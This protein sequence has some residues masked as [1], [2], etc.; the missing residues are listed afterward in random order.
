MWN[1]FDSLGA[2]CSAKLKVCLRASKMTLRR[3]FRFILLR[4]KSKDEPNFR[5]RFQYYMHSPFTDDSRSFAVS[6]HTSVSLVNTS[7]FSHRRILYALSTLH[8]LCEQKLFGWDKRDLN[9]SSS[10]NI[11][12]SIRQPFAPCLSARPTLV[13][14][15][16]VVHFHFWCNH[17]P[18][19]CWLDS[20]RGLMCLPRN[21]V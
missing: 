10:A 12:E 20:S 21:E 8:T 13:A 17:Q 3:C 19:K 16:F 2:A 6:L 7:A 4:T 5:L 15:V 11:I 9:I 1:S 14:F 18:A